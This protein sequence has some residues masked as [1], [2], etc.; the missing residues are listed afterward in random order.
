MITEL[1]RGFFGVISVFSTICAAL[2]LLWA[3]A[4]NVYDEKQARKQM[5]YD[6]FRRNLRRITDE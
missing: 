5:R 1:I 2:W 6:R 3:F 4:E